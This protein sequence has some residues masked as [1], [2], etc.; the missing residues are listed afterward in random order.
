[1]FDTRLHFTPGR[2]QT[3]WKKLGSLKY[4]FTNFICKEVP[5]MRL[6]HWR[7]VWTYN[8]VGNSRH[9]LEPWNIKF[10]DVGE[11][12]QN[13]QG[14]NTT[15]NK[16]VFELLANYLLGNNLYHNRQNEPFLTTN[17]PGTTT[18]WQP[19]ENFT[20]YLC[21][22]KVNDPEWRILLAVSV[23]QFGLSVIV[24]P[25]RHHPSSIDRNISPLPERHGLCYE[26]SD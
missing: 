3:G 5:K 15:R 7:C 21:T 25:V 18:K 20:F 6:N 16:G 22:G 26:P 13:L 17:F 1:M 4:L 9:R 23:T 12:K 24:N 8:S 10:W 11:D 2:V 19:W 14:R